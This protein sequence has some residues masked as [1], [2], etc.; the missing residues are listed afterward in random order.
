MCVCG[1][2]SYNLKAHLPQNILQLSQ[3]APIAEDQV[4]KAMSLSGAFHIQTVTVDV[5]EMLNK[6]GS[7]TQ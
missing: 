7:G 6:L 5:K 1:G 4:F 2:L 3:T